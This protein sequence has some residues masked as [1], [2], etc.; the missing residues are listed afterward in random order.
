MHGLYPKAHRRDYAEQMARLFRDQCR[1]AYRAG[2]SIGLMKL[3]LRTLPD[4]G[5]TSFIEQVTAVERKNIMNYLNAKNSPTILLLIGLA[6]GFLS[7]AFT[8]SADLLRLI[9][10]ASAIAILAKAAVE[11]FRSSDEWRI[12]L[13]RTFILMFLYAF[14]MPAWAKAGRTTPEG[15]K[16]IITSCLFANPVVALMK[17]TQFLVRRQKS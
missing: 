12:M 10:S 16:V 13:L 7:I 14:F 3:W 9:V 4:I 5:K 6:L 8:Q 11:L 2:R 15:F 1:A 17:L